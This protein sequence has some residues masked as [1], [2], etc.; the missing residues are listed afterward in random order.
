MNLLIPL[1]LTLLPL[2]AMAAT[3]GC[4]AQE[5]TIA[6]AETWKRGASLPVH[7][8]SKGHHYWAMMYSKSDTVIIIASQ[9]SAAGDRSGFWVSAAALRM[10][11][12]QAPETLREFILGETIIVGGVRYR[13]VCNRKPKSEL[14]AP[15]NQG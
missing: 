11:A 13:E 5:S 7:Y 2:P 12:E 9:P 15:V 8:W 1:A 10:A 14:T 4:S 6:A 3:Y